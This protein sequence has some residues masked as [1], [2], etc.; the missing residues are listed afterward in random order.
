MNEE[1]ASQRNA[2]LIAVENGDSNLKTI[3]LLLSKGC[4]INARN[5]FVN[6]TLLEAAYNGQNEAID[7][8]LGKGMDLNSKDNKGNTALHFAAIQGKDD[9]VE[10][11]LGQ[12]INRNE[13]NSFG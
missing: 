3:Q 9:T 8:L 5:S 12:G 7:F 2:L 11:L 1:D 4:D 6:D 13:R 10:F